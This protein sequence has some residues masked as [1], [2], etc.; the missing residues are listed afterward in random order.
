MRHANGSCSSSRI[1]H[2]CDCQQHLGTQLL[3]IAVK[4]THCTAC[5]CS[6]CCPLQD[7]EREESGKAAAVAAAGGL[8]GYLP[9]FLLT[10]GSSGLQSLLSLAA[11]VAGCV[12][13]G[14]TY[15]YAVRQDVDNLQVGCADFGQLRS[16]EWLVL[17]EP[18]QHFLRAGQVWWCHGA[19]SDTTWCSAPWSQQPSW[20]RQQL[21]CAP[22]Q[23]PAELSSLVS[24]SMR[25]VCADTCLPDS[26]T[27]CW[28]VVLCANFLLG[29]SCGEVLLQLL[30]S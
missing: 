23:Q 14:V 22:F 11:A 29:C 3:H 19:R 6:R 26:C 24:A 15:R 7:S 20:H 16:E 28:S 1:G 8:A 13:F 30:P 27:D 9:F 25:S 18:Q 12:L 10:S 21:C 4:G 5:R 17:V 2:G